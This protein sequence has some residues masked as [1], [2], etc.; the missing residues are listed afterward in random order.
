MANL[1]GF[2]LNLLKVFDAMLRE[3]STV[4]AGERLGLSQPAVS[5][6]LKRLRHAIGDPLFVRH[7]QRLVP[8]SRAQALEPALRRAIEAIEGVLSEPEAFTPARAAFDFRISGTDFFA[9]LLMPALVRQL[10]TAA[11]GVRVQLVDLVPDSYVA[12]LVRFD[13]D[14]ALIPVTDFPAWITHEA[15]FREHFTVIAREGH[16]ALSGVAPGETL[17]LDIFCRLGH[18]LCS[19]EGRFHGLCDV[20][21]ARIGRT[22]RV[23]AAVPVFEGVISIVR[24]SDLIALVPQAL[25]LARAEGGGF[26]VYRP[27]VA[28]TP[29]LLCMAWQ[30]RRSE[31]PAHRWMR[32]QV[33]AALSALAVAGRPAEEPPAAAGRGGSTGPASGAPAARA[34]HGSGR[35]PTRTE[36][37]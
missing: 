7:G 8:T 35:M 11:P 18:V 25:A 37:A 14:L 23:V 32:G 1:A 30:R 27:P 34:R 24:G 6:A 9:S 2:D 36:S 28:V 22:R 19:P 20:A 10:G 29:P 3:G 21:L 17:P 12:A 31:D 16:P 26:R 5:A 4:R 33:R 13:V 15:L